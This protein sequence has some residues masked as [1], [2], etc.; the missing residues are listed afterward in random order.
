MYVLIMDAPRKR[1]FNWWE[2]INAYPLSTLCFNSRS[3]SAI[4]WAFKTLAIVL[5]FDFEGQNLAHIVLS[6]KPDFRA[7]CN[8]DVFLF[9][10]KIRFFWVDSSIVLS[11]FI[12][13]PPLPHISM[14]R[15]TL[16]TALFPESFV[17]PL[18]LASCG[19]G[20]VGEMKHP[21]VILVS[22]QTSLE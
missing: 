11:Y 17:P 6:W 15:H 9:I 20:R 10:W 14:P 3:L 2:C 4:N 8:H 13:R 22:Y 7:F 21:R 18:N 12:P 16:A 19:V 5:P 1:T